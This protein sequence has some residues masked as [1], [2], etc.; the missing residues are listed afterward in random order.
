MIGYACGRVGFRHNRLS[1]WIPGVFKDK[2]MLDNT[3]MVTTKKES[4]TLRLGETLKELLRPIVTHK[5]LRYM[6]W[7]N[8]TDLSLGTFPYYLRRLTSL[9]LIEH[10]DHVYTITMKGVMQ[11]CVL[12]DNPMQTLAD[13]V[14]KD[15]LSIKGDLNRLS[16]RMKALS[17]LVNSA[18]I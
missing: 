1:K 12:M 9:G 4:Y 3:T 5:E 18:K 6:D 11:Y 15:Y 14:I 13:E 17:S 2:V 8:Q 7:L 10:N 16:K